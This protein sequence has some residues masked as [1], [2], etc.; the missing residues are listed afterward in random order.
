MASRPIVSIVADLAGTDWTEQSVMQIM[1][2]TLTT[3]EIEHLAFCHIEAYLDREERVQVRSIETAVRHGRKCR[4]PAEQAEWDAFREESDARFASRVSGLLKQYAS[5]LRAEWT[6]ELLES[7]FALPDGLH[8]TWGTATVDQH[9]ERAQ[10]LSQ[11]AVGTLETA[12]LHRKAIE[13]IR[14]GGVS[15]LVEMKE[16]AA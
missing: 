8:V 5:E 7:T 13:D 2:E 4:T 16:G 10:M 6:Q 3:E 14:A 15:C 11:Q 9:M 1:R 12:A